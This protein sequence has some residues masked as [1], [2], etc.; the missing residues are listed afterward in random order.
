MHTYM[1]TVPINVGYGRQIKS[2]FVDWNAR[3]GIMDL[4]QFMLDENGS[5]DDDNGD[6]DNNNNDSEDDFKY[7]S[8]I[9]IISISTIPQR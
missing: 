8:D 6:G 7:N 1:H 5:D 9:V 2:Q 3:D 4:Y